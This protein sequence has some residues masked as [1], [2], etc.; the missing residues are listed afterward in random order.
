MIKKSTL[1]F[2]EMHGCYF[3]TNYIFTE[4][5]IFFIYILFINN[6]K[7]LLRAIV[8]LTGTPFIYANF[9]KLTYLRD[10]CR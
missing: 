10:T 4:N 5:K 9:N 1:L 6:T 3:R 7:H 2:H 8:S